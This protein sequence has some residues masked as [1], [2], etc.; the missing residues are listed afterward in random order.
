[1]F[2]SSVKEGLIW[3]EPD[4]VTLLS[5][6]LHFPSPPLCL[7]VRENKPGCGF[8]SLLPHYCHQLPGRNSHLQIGEVKLSTTGCIFL[9]WHQYILAFESLIGILSWQLSP[10]CYQSWLEVTE[11]WTQEQVKKGS[12]RLYCWFM[13]VCLLHSDMLWIVPYRRITV[14]K[15]RTHAHTST[16]TNHRNKAISHSGAV[17]L[18]TAIA[19]LERHWT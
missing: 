14:K 8:G 9:C 16:R 13:L 3:L 10:R 15:L 6:L 12:D 7:R 17:H 19:V 4:P 18:H 1:M 11:K 2:C 5:S